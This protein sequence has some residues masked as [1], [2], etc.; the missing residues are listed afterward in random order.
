M[1]FYLLS[2]LPLH[3]RKFRLAFCVNMYC[4][5]RGM[6][7]FYHIFHGTFNQSHFSTVENFLLFKY[8]SKLVHSNDTALC[9]EFKHVFGLKSVTTKD[10]Q[11]DKGRLSITVLHSLQFRSNSSMVVIVFKC[12]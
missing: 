11:I 2:H 8:C 3:L 5:Q 1:N 12:L 6:K 10:G 4:F 7:I 9:G